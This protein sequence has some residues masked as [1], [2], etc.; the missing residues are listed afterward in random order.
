[1]TS[2]NARLS[3]AR[4][5]GALR[6]QLSE[7][8]WASVVGA[9]RS[10]GANDL[11]GMPPWAEPARAGAST[12]PEGPHRESAVRVARTGPSHVADQGAVV[13]DDALLEAA[14]LR[15]PILEIELATS[16]GQLGLL[17]VIR[18]DLTSA[19]TV[20]RRVTTTP[21]GGPRATS[22]LEG[23]EVSAFPLDRLMDEVMRLVPDPGD[24]VTV[25]PAA[26]PMELSVALGAAL[27]R[28]DREM[29]AAICA[30]LR[31]G[32]APEIVRSLVHSLTGSC[33]VTIRGAVEGPVSVG[34]WMLADCGWVEVAVDEEDIVHHRPLSRGDI[35]TRILAATVGRVAS[36]QQTGA[37]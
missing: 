29:V 12:A 14:L 27:R 31:L 25:A 18:S 10:A 24:V 23:I 3:L 11:P 4:E 13:V 37:R 21:G 35:R 17:G 8:E 33:A 26:I 1:M 20:V 5:D 28:G 36:L 15:A 9:A 7:D 34:S 2:M 16:H 22:L 32:E 6:A 30:D 19:S